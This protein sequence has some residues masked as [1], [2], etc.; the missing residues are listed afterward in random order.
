MSRGKHVIQLRQFHLQLAFAAARM[1]RKNIQDQL[2]AIDD[3]AFGVFFDVALLHRRKVAV[4]NNQR[5]IFGDGFGAN[6]IE[7]A[8]ADQR[9]GI[10]LIAQLKHGSGDGGAGAAREFDQ[11]SQGFAFRR[12]GCNSGHARENASRRRRRA[13]RAQ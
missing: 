9:C 11:F 7:L 5:R 10:S 6:F 13:V 8:A 1:P 3:P 2:R 12:A 4:E